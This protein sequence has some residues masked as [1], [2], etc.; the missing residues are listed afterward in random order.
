[1]VFDSYIMDMGS[2]PDIIMH[3][4][5]MIK[6]SAQGM[7]AHNVVSHV[8]DLEILNVGLNDSLLDY[9]LVITRL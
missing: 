4:K 3:L 6:G 5:L 7:R 2:L 8:S 9:Y 1:M